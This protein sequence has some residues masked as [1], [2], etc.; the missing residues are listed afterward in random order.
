MDCLVM[1]PLDN[2]SNVSFEPRSF[3]GIREYIEIAMQM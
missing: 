2:A 1:A 3:L